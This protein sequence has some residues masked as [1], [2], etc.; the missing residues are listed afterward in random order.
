MTEEFP[1]RGQRHS[2]GRQAA[3][4][5]QTYLRRGRPAAEL[6]RDLAFSLAETE[7]LVGADPG[8]DYG[9]MFVSHPLLGRNDVPALLR[10]LALHERCH[11]SQI[12]E[13]ISDPRSPGPFLNQSEGLYALPTATDPR[14]ALSA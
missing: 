11:Q 4:Q 14:R 8:L 9:S 6:R 2:G 10:L 5:R 12:A 7:A 1:I 13:I 3:H